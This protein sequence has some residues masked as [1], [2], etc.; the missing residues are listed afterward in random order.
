MTHSH[1]QIG[2]RGLGVRSGY[3]QPKETAVKKP[4]PDGFHKCPV[5]FAS[6]HYV[7]GHAV[8]AAP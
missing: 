5:T 8:N 7:A 6:A 2:L 4:G 3:C 1:R